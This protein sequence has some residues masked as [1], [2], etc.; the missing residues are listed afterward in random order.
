[1]TQTLQTTTSESRDD[2]KITREGNDQLR[3]NLSQFTSQQPNNYNSPNLFPFNSLTHHSLSISFNPISLDGPPHQSSSLD[4]TSSDPPIPSTYNNSSILHA[5]TV[6]TST[7]S[8]SSTSTV[9]SSTSPN[10]TP[11]P[12]PPIPPISSPTPTPV[13]PQSNPHNPHPIP[14]PTPFPP[15]PSIYTH[16]SYPPTSNFLQIPTTTIHVPKYF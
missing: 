9:N 16:H 12:N 6:T 13:P 15:T 2:L 10:P 4:H 3:A 1:M 14:N 8:L 7:S 5:S 11:I